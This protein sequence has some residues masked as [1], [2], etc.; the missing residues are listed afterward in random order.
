MVTS[1]KGDQ[2]PP[3]FA[4]MTVIPVN[5]KRCSRPAI[6]FLKRETITI[7]VVRLSSMADKKKVIDDR[8]IEAIVAGEAQRHVAIYELAYVQAFC[9]TKVVPT[10]TVRMRGPAG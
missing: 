5:S 10:A 4:A 6:N 2:A 8:D 1:P 9:G 3:A 7:V